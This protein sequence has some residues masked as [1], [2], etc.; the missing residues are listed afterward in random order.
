MQIAYRLVAADG[1]KV[2]D[3]FW[4]TV[5]Y[6]EELDFMAEGFTSLNRDELFSGPGVWEDVAVNGAP[7][8]AERGSVLFQRMGCMGCHT[9]D[10]STGTGVGPTMK[11]LYGSE[12]NFRDGSTAIADENYLRQKIKN[13]GTSIVAG[14]DEG[15]PSF[16][17]ILSEDEI[18][19]VILYI[20]SLSN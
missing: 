6:T 3:T 10:G 1:T 11:D 15:M 17:G 12:R 14:Y 20:K 18:N 9:V 4:F 16:L 19:S 5:H 2:E 7:V 8:S 13:P